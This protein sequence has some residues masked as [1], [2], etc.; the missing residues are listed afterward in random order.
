MFKQ[1]AAFLLCLS[2]SGCA[3]IGP[4]RIDKCCV[5]HDRQLTKTENVVGWASVGGIVIGWPV[6]IG[7][8]FGGNSK[9]CGLS[10]A[11]IGVSTLS[12][13]WAMGAFEGIGYCHPQDG[14]YKDGYY[15]K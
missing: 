13:W 6:F 5:Y 9:L 15:Y 14:C 10:F 8:F 7:S 1:I 2:I 4:R 12:A 11:T 3:S